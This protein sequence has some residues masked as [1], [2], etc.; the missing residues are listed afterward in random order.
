MNPVLARKRP[1]KRSKTFLV[2]DVDCRSGLV[3]SRIRDVSRSGALLESDQPPVAGEDIQIT[4]GG[5]RAAARVAW[6]EGPWF[7]IEFATELA[8]G[9]LVVDTGTSLRV[10]ASRTY[11]SSDA[12]SIN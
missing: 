4:C 9:V 10:S 7:G 1:V 5:F 11:R 6:S 3:E 12:F 2:A 8:S